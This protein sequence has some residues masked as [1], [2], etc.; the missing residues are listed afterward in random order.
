MPRKA[1][2]KNKAS[3]HPGVF[4]TFEL[5]FKMREAPMGEQWREF[6]VSTCRLLTLLCVQVFRLL[7]IFTNFILVGRGFWIHLNHRQEWF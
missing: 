3:A 1:Q 6:S 2:N 4:V 7:C 5:E